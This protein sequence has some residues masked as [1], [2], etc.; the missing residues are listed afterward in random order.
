MVLLNRYVEGVDADR[1]TADNFEGARLA[2]HHLA[3][4]GHER[5]GIISGPEYTST[6]RD[7]YKGFPAGSGSLRPLHE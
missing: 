7:R 6:G 3:E 4:L 1:I 2:A 5:I